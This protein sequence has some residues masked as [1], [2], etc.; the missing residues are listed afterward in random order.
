VP[1][2]PSLLFWS[3]R[4]ARY[5]LLVGAYLAAPAL[6]AALLGRGAT[7][8]HR[9]W[10]AASPFLLLGAW[11]L[12]VFAA[13]PAGLPAAWTALWTP[14][15]LL[16]L[17]G[18]LAWF[19]AAR[20]AAA[21]PGARRLLRAAG[22]VGPRALAA[23]L[24]LGL[25]GLYTLLTV[26]ED[27]RDMLV[28]DE[29]HYLL[30]MESLRRYGTADLTRIYA[31]ER[32]P[33]GIRKIEAHKT[34]TSAPGT[35]Y[36][37]HNVGLPALLVPWFAA[38]GYRGAIWFFNVVTALVAALAFLLC[39][40]V[41]GRRGWS[42]LAAAL[43]G[44]S[45]PL[46]AYARFVYPEMAG[47]LAVV[48]AFLVLRR[49]RPG[50][51]ALLLAGA[52]AGF[53]PWLHVKFLALTGAL[54]LLALVRHRREPR[55]LAL[56]LLPLLPAGLLLMRFFH[57]A[58]GSW[59][60]NAQYG[61]EEPP[62]SAFVFRGALGLLLDRDHGLLAFAP[63]WWL[64]VPGCVALW[65]TSRR[66][67]VETLAVTLPAF[68][69]FSS[70]WMWWGGPC[71]AGRFLIPLLPLWAP[72]LAAGA[73]RRA[74][75]VF[76]L[77]A[78]W[79]VAITLALSLFALR[80]TAALPFHRHFLRGL[81]P[82]Y[83]AF[84][85]LP[86]LFFHKTE[87]VPPAQYAFA[88]GWLAALAAAAALLARRGRRPVSPR[89]F[90]WALGEARAG[91]VVAA[92]AL[93]LGGAGL[94]GALAPAAGEAQLAAVNYQL[95][96]YARPLARAGADPSALAARIPP[97]TLRAVLPGAAA[98]R[99]VDARALAGR[100]EVPVR[101]GDHTLLYPA[102]Y[103]VRFGVDVETAAAGAVGRLDVSAFNGRRIL[104]QRDFTAADVAGGRVLAARF[105]PDGI[106]ERAEF[107][108]WAKA[109]GSFRVRDALLTVS[110]P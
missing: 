44:T 1:E 86:K 103:E 90:A 24:F 96:A 76:R 66:A 104:W 13:H 36:E 16:L 105:R 87:A 110:I 27:R 58:Y 35:T 23:V 46:F 95:D 37:V 77:L 51:P 47:A 3:P 99:G 75:P 79:S 17:S 48:F 62:V 80:E 89:G 4:I 59:M 100:P 45:F 106:L 85:T 102:G 8:G 33:P 2:G 94:A 42:F 54:A 101:T 69:V 29:P 57:H 70:H 92:G 6:V 19:R 28:G 98:A 26:R 108:C 9:A 40:E 83:D 60:P 41:T 30:V 18:A 5:L 63:A 14:G 7:P 52:G 72:A 20:A 64:L 78:F 34:H 21:R 12:A 61:T 91:A 55:R 50:A 10:T 82:G 32:L 38:G 73:G 93:L 53:L 67:A 22:A 56:F 43:L 84:A 88:L 81:L 49:E 68:A 31:D 11:P 25:L 74:G 15:V 39:V 71:P 109:P 107:R 97:R 65:R